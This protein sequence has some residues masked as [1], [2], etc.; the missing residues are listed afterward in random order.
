MRSSLALTA[1]LGFLP[2]TAAHGEE[3]RPAARPKAVTPVQAYGKIRV[4]GTQ[5]CSAS[6]RPV[7][8]RGMSS[9]GTQWFAHCLTGR[10]MD[11]LAYDW[12][13]SVV[14]VATYVRRGGYQADP[15]KFT[16]I[17]HKVIERA[18][19]RGLY[20]VVDWHTTQP[21]DPNEDFSDAKRFFQ[22]IAQRHKHRTNVIYE[23]ANEPNHVSWSRI[24]SYAE[25]L[26]PV[27]RS[28]DPDSVILVPT[29]A[30]STFSGSEHSDERTVVGNP[31]AAKN[32][33]Y[34]FHFYAR[35][36]P[37]VFMDILDRASSKVPVFVTEWGIASWTGYGSDIPKAQKWIDLMAEK[38]ISWTNWSFSDNDRE[39][40]VFKKDTCG[41]GTF[42]RSDALTPNGAWIRERIRG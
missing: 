3:P 16:D 34:T 29:P 36:A 10:A 22:E 27:I 9:H 1:A 20:V 13:A 21:G 6:G 37:K 7:Q 5:L 14:R 39:H 12:K 41:A 15:K 23:I 28:H 2:A 11:A 31:V 30:W 18:S 32:I 8:L 42:T 40:S 38:N 24:K 26:I 4:C 17:V 33:M 35:A 19:A 25:K